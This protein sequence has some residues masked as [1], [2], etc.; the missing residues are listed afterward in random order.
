MYGKDAMSTPHV[1]QQL[2]LRRV[3]NGSA[4]LT[5][6]GGSLMPP[7]VLDAMRDG[8][9]LDRSGKPMNIPVTSAVRNDGTLTW[10]TAEVSLA[11]LAARLTRI[12]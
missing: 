1:Y 12:G 8:H 7:E 2:G 11:P 4:T 5:R 6:L 9:A 3:I 10:A